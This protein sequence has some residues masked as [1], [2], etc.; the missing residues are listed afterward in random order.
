MK[1]HRTIRSAVGL[2][3]VAVLSAGVATVVAGANSGTNGTPDAAGSSA[4]VGV[5]SPT[6]S[7]FV[8]VTPCRLVDTRRPGAGGPLADR[9]TRSYRT[10]GSTAGQGGGT[11]CNIPPTASAVDGQRH[12]SRGHRQRVP[13]PVPCD[14]RASPT[15]PS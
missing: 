1:V 7:N 10:Q 9:Q 8:P 6:E 14:R 13:A 5:Q 15:R 2:G 12:G 11:A 4:R 3:I